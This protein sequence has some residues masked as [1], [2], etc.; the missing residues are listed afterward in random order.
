MSVSANV[1]FDGLPATSMA[2]A[3]CILL[4]RMR[5]HQPMSNTIPSLKVPTP[6]ITAAFQA[7]A[8]TAA[9]ATAA[10]GKLHDIETSAGCNLYISAQWRSLPPTGI[11]HVYDPSCVHWILDR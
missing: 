9:L 4:L 10:A 5:I 3:I 1:R 11:E 7:V 6:E 8:S 2:A